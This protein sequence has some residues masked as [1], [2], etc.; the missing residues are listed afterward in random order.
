MIETIHEPTSDVLSYFETNLLRNALDIWSLTKERSRYK[1]RMCR[2]GDEL[3][4][5]LGIFDTPEAKY[6]S[7]GGSAQAAQAL[8]SFIPEKAALTIPPSFRNLVRTAIK[9]DAIYPN[10]I[11]VVE[12]GNEKLEEPGAAERLTRDDAAEYAAFGSSFNVGKLSH[13]WAKDR[14]ERNIIL[15]LFQGG[16]LVSVASIA[17]WLPKVA[18]ILAV[19]TK[20]EYRGKG[21]GSLVVSAAVREALRR[22]ESC[23][24]FVRSDN[25]PAIGLYRRL[26]FRKV[27]EELWI[28]IGTGIVP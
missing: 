23:S 18:V 5:H 19:E 17:A 13:K 12:R 21:Y 27:A 1:L 22:S 28:D 24:L 26:G 15:G 4:A 14:L 2:V 20:Q 6:T 16:S 10:D 3:K 11:M 25:H 8:I 9:H 7:L